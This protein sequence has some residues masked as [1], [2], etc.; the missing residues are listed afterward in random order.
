M[1]FNLNLIL[2]VGAVFLLFS[3]NEKNKNKSKMTNDKTPKTEK[4]AAK[5]PCKDVHWS[6]DKE[7]NKPENWKTLC[8][9]FSACGGKVQSPINIITKD[10]KEATDQQKP[11]LNYDKSKIDI[12]NNGHT[13]VFNIDS[14]NSL[15]L[16]DKE[17]KL[18]QFHFHALSEHTIDGEHFPL[19][20]H[21]VHQHNDTDFVVIG[22]IY[23]EGKENPML[24]KHLTNINETMA[25]FSSSG[26]IDLKT[27]LPETKD[28]YNYNGSLTTPPCSEYVNWYLIKEPIEASKAQLEKFAKVLHNNFR[29]TQPLN[30][31]EV[32][33]IK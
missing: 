7:E 9:G 16:N 10:L 2:I 4:S 17:Y 18:L 32:K 22:A 23:K 25:T 26:L 3:C 5:K 30:G 21:F 20:V 28:Y 19:E 33:Y 24:E 11:V 14:G 27:I 6:Y 8:S 13:V 15:M 12:V 1:K 29:P 31:R